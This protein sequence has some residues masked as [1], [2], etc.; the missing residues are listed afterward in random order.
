MLRISRDDISGDEIQYYDP[1]HRFIK[2]SVAKYFEERGM[3]MSRPQIAI[4]NAL[5]S[6]NYKFVVAA[7]SRRLGKTYIANVIAHLVSMIPGVNILVMSPNY[8]LSGIS[9]DLQEELMRHSGIESERANLKDRVIVMQNNSTIRL[10]SINQVDSSIGRSYNFII[11][12]E[13]A[14]ADGGK[15]AFETQLLPTL[16]RPN[17]KVLF[18]S[19]PRGKKNWF[20]EYYYRGYS[21]DQ[22][23]WISIQADYRE[24]SRANIEDI[25]AARKSMSV[26]KFKQE[27][28]AD[29]NVFEG[30]VY[31][32]NADKCVEDLSS[33]DW[34][35]LERFA[36]VDIG[37]KDP[38][39]VVVLGYDETTQI[40]YI[41]DEYQNSE[42]KTS[43][44][45]TA[46][47]EMMQKY[48]FDTV[49]VDSAA[50]QTRFDWA[51]E[52][53]IPTIGAK[54]SVLD[55][56]AFVQAI[57]EQDRLVVDERCNFTLAMLDQFRW[58]DRP[59][60]LTEKPVH[61]IHVHI[62][63]ALRYAVYT[64]SVASGVF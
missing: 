30:Q 4:V 6:A 59:M 11:F 33:M 64:H 43:D 41:L 58:D 10:G 39:A 35:K 9:Y 16:D 62:A 22:P 3:T 7:V 19:T 47:K 29:F 49:Y 48:E 60:L 57:V 51:Y 34:T 15:D 37:F 14:V 23:K 26:A 12:D 56:I 40:Y 31:R 28:E 2:L 45:A 13:A 24:N 44:H 5:N 1:A 53:D 50:A 32:F 20:A 54:K 61:D 38:T 8:T 63:D 46:I 52:Y 27:F 17:S 42:A 25:E 18:I 36:G 55:G 21:S